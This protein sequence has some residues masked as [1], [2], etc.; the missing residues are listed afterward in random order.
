VKKDKAFNALESLSKR[1]RKLKL[2]WDQNTEFER[3]ATDSAELIEANHLNI[4]LIAKIIE[5]ELMQKVLQDIFYGE[6]AVKEKG[7]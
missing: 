1:K 7:C 4:A 6:E 2:S 5:I 3:K